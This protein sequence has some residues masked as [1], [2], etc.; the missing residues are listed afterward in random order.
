MR[1]YWRE[2]GFR[3]VM[4]ESPLHVMMGQ[5]DA[6]HEIYCQP[7]EGEPG[8]DL[9][10]TYR[11]EFY[12][13]EME[14]VVQ[15]VA[16]TQ[17]DFVFG[18]I[19]CW[20]S[21]EN[22]S[23]KC[24]RCRAVWENF[25]KSQADLGIAMNGSEKM[26][27]VEKRERFLWMQGREIVRDLHDT[28]HRGA[29]SSQISVSVIGSYARQ[30]IRPVYAIEHF[31]DTYPEFVDMAMPSLYVAGRE[32]DAHRNIREN[33][34]L[35]G[36]SRL[37][38]WLSAGCCGEFEPEKL[39]FMVL[40]S[41]LNGAGGITYYCF[42]DFDT[43]LDFYAHARALAALRPYEEL[44]VSGEA[45]E[46]SGSVPEMLYSSWGTEKERLILIG[47]PDRAEEETVLSLAL[48]GGTVSKLCVKDLRSGE[49][50]TVEPGKF[51]CTVPKGGVRLFHISP[52]R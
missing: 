43:P 24:E 15:C 21:A 49:E 11:G 45:Q 39:E 50:E 1:E 34:A 19:E 17:P 29:Q 14:R 35:L 22:S 48:G 47:N 44:L 7:V 36:N 51:T 10:P 20:H 16:R 26:S 13:A 30:P 52:K 4:N 41:F 31:S 23:K 12:A 38:P 32:R 9:C 37:I 5:K 6:G 40:E 28:V 18:D 46:I 2:A 25:Q 27:E 33:H 8:K 42:T 3:G